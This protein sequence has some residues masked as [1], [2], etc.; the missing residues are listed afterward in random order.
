MDS[1]LGCEHPVTMVARQ[2]AESAPNPVF[3]NLMDIGFCAPLFDWPCAV[4]GLTEHEMIVAERSRE[5]NPQ[6]FIA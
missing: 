1:V 4:A 5:V 6:S 3:I 2:T